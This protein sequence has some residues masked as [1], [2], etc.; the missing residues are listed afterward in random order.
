MCVD[1]S[2]SGSASEILILSVWYVLMCSCISIL[3]CQTK[4]NNV[5]KV[6]FLPKTHEEVVW[7]NISMDKVFWMNVLYSANLKKKIY[8]N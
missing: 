8:K 1:T 7:F 2:V 5:H 3:F 6:S 4:I